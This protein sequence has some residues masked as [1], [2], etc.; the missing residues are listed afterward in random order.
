MQKESP[1]AIVSRICRGSRGVFPGRA[2]VE[3]GLW[4]NQLLW[5]HKQGIVERVFPDTYRLTAVE[6]SHEQTLR[7]ALLW[8]GDSAAAAGR[9]AAVV[10]G[11]E[12][13]RPGVPQIVSFRK[14]P[15][16][17]SSRPTDAAGTTTPPTRSRQREVERPGGHGYR[18]VLATWAKITRDPE[19][20]VAE[21]AATRALGAC[22]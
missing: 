6:P 13:V 16:A 21:L 10:Y 20:F 19:A 11:L 17:P 3:A 18:I 9:S 15:T 5:M 2:A 22:A 8:A 4:R 12:G 7:A 1:V 14:L